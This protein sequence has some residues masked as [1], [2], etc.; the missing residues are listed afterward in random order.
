MCVRKESVEKLLNLEGTFEDP[1]SVNI[2]VRFLRKR[3]AFW[4]EPPL[5]QNHVAICL[6]YLRRMKNESSLIFP[7]W[8]I[9]RCVLENTRQAG[10]DDISN[11]WWRAHHAGNIW[12]I[13]NLKL[14][15]KHT[16]NDNL[17]YVLALVEEDFES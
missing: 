9:L 1:L 4:V 14:S 5:E 10:V 3:N 12:F 2:S 7:I 8:Q 16:N 13:L 15:K 11:T 17:H 6:N